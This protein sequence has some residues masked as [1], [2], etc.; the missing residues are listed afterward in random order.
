MSNTTPA[1]REYTIAK[2][3]L[4]TLTTKLDKLVKRAGKLGVE[5][6]TY[7]VSAPRLEEVVVGEVEDDRGNLKPVK[8]TIEVVDVVV[9]GSPPSLK[10]W[11]FLATIEPFDDKVMIRAVP[12][13]EVPVSYRDADPEHCDHCQKR[14]QRLA[15]FVVRHTDTGEYKQVGRN[16]VA[17]F[18]GH[19]LPLSWLTFMGELSDLDEFAG[20]LGRSEPDAWGLDVFLAL[21]ACDIRQSHWVSRTAARESPIK[22]ATV[23]CVLGYLWN[24]HKMDPEDRAYWKPTQADR[25]TAAKAIEWAQGLPEDAVEASDYLYNVSLVVGAEYTTQRT[26]G[27]AA[28]IIAAYHRELGRQVERAKDKASEHF[29]EIKKRA[30]YTLT[31]VRHTGWDSQF[32]YTNLYVFR[33]PEGNLAT[34]KSKNYIRDP[35]CYTREAAVG[36]TITVKATVKEHTEYKGTKQTVLTR[37]KVLGLQKA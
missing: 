8:G 12:N 9:S 28:S 36:D 35:E 37:C 21:V 5:G 19:R 26:A 25:D 11:E 16:C 33:T 10:G 18:L 32:G 27:I 13:T 3:H 17:D 1:T 30:D 24:A 20:S 15:T 14:R 29:G 31:L 22:V 7:E 4:A 2:V 6:L 34:W 23:D